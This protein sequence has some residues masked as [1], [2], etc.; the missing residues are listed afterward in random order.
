MG[1]FDSIQNFIGGAA[2]AAQGSIG[3]V[4]GGLTE[5]TGVQDVQELLGGASE[6]VTSATEGATEALTNVTEQAQGV[7]EDITNGFGL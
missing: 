5:M 3:D 2:D 7:I 4:V 6:T 1:L